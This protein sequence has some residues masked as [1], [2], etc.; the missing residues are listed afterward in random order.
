MKIVEDNLDIE[1][2]GFHNLFQKQNFQFTIS[3]FAGKNYVS[4]IR[5][6]ELFRCQEASFFVNGKRSVMFE[7]TFTPFTLK[8]ISY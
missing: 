7:F 5:I 1:I 6:T 4:I 3:L 2:W 8:H